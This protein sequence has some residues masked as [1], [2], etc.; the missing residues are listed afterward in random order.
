MVWICRKLFSTTRFIGNHDND[1]CEMKAK[2]TIW[3]EAMSGSLVC[4]GREAHYSLLA[5]L[6]RCLSGA[7]TGSL[8]V[9]ILI[10]RVCELPSVCKVTT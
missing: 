4:V 2:D 6:Q 8:H 9:L 3:K 10:L 7:I 5:R 1:C